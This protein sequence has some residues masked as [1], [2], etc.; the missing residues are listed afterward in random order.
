MF[1]AMYLSLGSLIWFGRQKTVTHFTIWALDQIVC[2]IQHVYDG[3]ERAKWLLSGAG[4]MRPPRDYTKIK[5]TF[6]HVTLRWINRFHFRQAARRTRYPP[7]LLLEVDANIYTVT[8][9]SCFRD[10]PLES[11]RI[12]CNPFS[13]RSHFGLNYRQ[14]IWHK[15]IQN[16]QPWKN[17]VNKIVPKNYSAFPIIRLN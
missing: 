13:V 6:A 10:L 5:W 4:N 9:P 14:H 15:Q 1:T 8:N 17:W 7:R 3:C 11:R 16:T 2:S 12:Q